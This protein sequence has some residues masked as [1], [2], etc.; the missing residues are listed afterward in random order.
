MQRGGLVLAGGAT[1]KAPRRRRKR[2]NRW[3]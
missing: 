1:L 3:V 2:D